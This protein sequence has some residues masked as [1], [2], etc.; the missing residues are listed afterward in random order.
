[1]LD[2]GSDLSASRWAPRAH[3]R[4]S[5][6]YYSQ[7]ST[8]PCRA[9]AHPRATSTTSRSPTR[10]HHPITSTTSTPTPHARK[11]H[12]APSPTQQRQHSLAL[13]ARLSTRLKWRASLL[14]TAHTF[15]LSPAAHGIGLDATEADAQFRIDFFEFYV[16]LERCLLLLLGAVG[17][18]VSRGY[19]PQRD[20][21]S[22]GPH[23]HRD[24]DRGGGA[25]R[26]VV[27]GHQ[28]GGYG[29]S[30]QRG[31]I[32]DSKVVMG[33]AGH[34]FHQNLLDALSC[35]DGNPLFDILGTGRVREYI[36][37]AKDLR[38]GWKETASEVPLVAGDT[39]ENGGVEA[40]KARLDMRL[41]RRYADLL[42]ELRLDEMLRVV[43]GAVEHAGSVAAVEVDRA[44]AEESQRIATGDADAQGRRL[45][46]DMT[47]VMADEMIGERPW[48]SMGPG[49]WEVDEMEF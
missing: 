20:D 36:G 6:P 21:D 17:V 11:P 27:D 32:G 7:I 35:A 33:G 13:F 44:V 38:N 3:A 31:L 12:T 42:S 37:L 9:H 18:K 43:L 19:D 1:M 29:T 30:R 16:L 22:G 15:A 2:S 14:L 26:V 47:D 46:V 41:K 4:T 39:E 40:E 5:S 25:R 34:S 23:G 49:T 24:R 8:S 45:S 48:E 28:S 10:P